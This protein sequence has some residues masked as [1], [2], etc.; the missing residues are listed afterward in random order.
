MTNG[1]GPHPR[2]GTGKKSS[3]RKKQAKPKKGSAL[4]SPALKAQAAGS[5]VPPASK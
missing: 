4:L 5:G 2:R 1:S 3:A